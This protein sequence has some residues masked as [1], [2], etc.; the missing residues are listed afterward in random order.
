MFS[1]IYTQCEHGTIYLIKIQ[2]DK[3]LYKLQKNEIFSWDVI[4]KQHLGT[5]M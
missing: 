5:S 1:L 4:S 3:R 2:S